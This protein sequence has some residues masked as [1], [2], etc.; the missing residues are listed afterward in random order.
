MAAWFLVTPYQTA[1]ARD[2]LSLGAKIEVNFGQIVSS[3]IALP[4]M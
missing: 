1:S 4:I 3:N 2:H